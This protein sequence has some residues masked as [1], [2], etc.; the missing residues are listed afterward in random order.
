MLIAERLRALMGSR[1]AAVPSDRLLGGLARLGIATPR[2]ETLLATL[3]APDLVEKLANQAA[4]AAQALQEARALATEAQRDRTAAETAW[5][6]AGRIKAE[7]EAANAAHAARSAEL[8]SRAHVTEMREA[9]VIM[10]EREVEKMLHDV[11]ALKTEYESKLAAI[12]AIVKG[13]ISSS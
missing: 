2:L 10:R 5:G 4:S 12:E 9:V 1:A 11:A 13:P 7:V 3:A 8:D 6:E